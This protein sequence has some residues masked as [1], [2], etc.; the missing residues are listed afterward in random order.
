MRAVRL[1]SGVKFDLSSD[2][3]RNLTQVPLT[4]FWRAV[5]W[6]RKTFFPRPN[7]SNPGLLVSMTK[8][9]AMGFLGSNH[10][11]PGWETSDAFFG[12][13]LNMRRPVCMPDHPTDLSWWQV[14]IRGYDHARGVVLA[15]HFEANPTEH[16][17]EHLEQ[18]GLDFNRGTAELILLLNA[19]GI[20]F[21]RVGDWSEW[22]D[23]AIIQE[24]D[25]EG[26]PSTNTEYAPE[27]GTS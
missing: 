21:E 22:T 12:E 13:T 3:V 11:E 14:H 9:E 18:V 5:W 24:S 23:D 2:R 20:E 27:N 4:C 10:F 26:D 6:G 19:D 8:L 1:L 25:S 7:P 15:A 16:L 17:T